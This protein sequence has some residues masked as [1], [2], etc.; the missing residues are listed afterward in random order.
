MTVT[1]EEAQASLTKLIENLAPG[2]EV[3]IT[4]DNQP[5]AKLVGECPAAASTAKPIWEVFEEVLRDVPAEELAKLPPDD[6]S[7]ID[8]YVY[9][10]RRNAG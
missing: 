5:V 6:A 7:N 9:G 8:F 1:I 10:I 3:V 4:R 2:E